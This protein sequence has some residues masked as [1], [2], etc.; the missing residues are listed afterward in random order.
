MTYEGMLAETVAFRGH[1]GDVGEAYYA[2]PLGGGPWPGVVLIHHMPGWDCGSRRRPARLPI[3][4]LRP[5]PRISTSAKVPAVPT[6]WARGCERRA[7]SPTRRSSATSQGRW[8]ICGR[9]LM[10]TARPG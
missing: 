6:T 3:A 10:P 4:D 2:R 7:A 9:S 8:N 1:N 5:S